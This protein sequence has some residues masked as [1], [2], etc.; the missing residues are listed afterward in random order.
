V[1]QYDRGVA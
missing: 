1:H